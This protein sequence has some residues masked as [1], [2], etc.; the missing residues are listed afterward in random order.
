MMC[1]LTIELANQQLQ[2]DKTIGWDFAAETIFVEPTAFSRSVTVIDVNKDMA[3]TKS[4][5][6]WSIERKKYE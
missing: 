1:N 4:L 6:E 5:V 2:C 3:P